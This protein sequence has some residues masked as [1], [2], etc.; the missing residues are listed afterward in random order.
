MV[1]RV[2]RVPRSAHNFHSI[3][4]STMLEQDKALLPVSIAAHPLIPFVNEGEGQAIQINPIRWIAVLVAVKV[5]YIERYAQMS[6]TF[7]VFTT[8]AP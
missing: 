1:M 2:E 7:T 6:T 5:S 4:L 3:D 8:E